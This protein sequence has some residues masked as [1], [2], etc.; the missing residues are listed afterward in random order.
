M[1][2][3]RQLIRNF[4]WHHTGSTWS[5]DAA[6]TYTTMWM[7]PLQ[8]CRGGCPW[9]AS[10]PM[11]GHSKC[12]RNLDLQ[13]Q[14][15]SYYSAMLNLMAPLHFSSSS[16][17]PYYSAILKLQNN[18]MLSSREDSYEQIESQPMN[19]VALVTVTVG[20]LVC[21][22]FA[23]DYICH[24]VTQDKHTLTSDLYNM[25]NSSCDR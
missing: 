1:T 15:S 6:D 5:H 16:E 25:M 2:L 17:A 13:F 10:Y 3:P 4:F 18:K 21:Y 23:R 14:A 20:M 22:W 11:G 12:F 19:I 7:V 24:S 9:N 8:Y